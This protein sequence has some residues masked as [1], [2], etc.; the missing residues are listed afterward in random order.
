MQISMCSVTYPA[1]L[2]AYTGQASFLR[3]NN[4]L[5]SDTF[6]KSIPPMISGTFSIIQQSLALGCFPCVKIV[7]TSAKYEGQVYIPEINFILLIACVAVTA[8]FKTTTK[9]GIAV[10]FV[11]TLTSALLVL[12][13]IMIWKSHI[14]LVINYVVVELIYSSSVLYKFGYLPLAFAAVLMIIMYIWNDVYRRNSGGSPIKRDF[15]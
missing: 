15:Q 13:M 14:L 8:G 7:H 2:L 6:Y 10:V 3:Q 11:M 9:I 4:D 12:I 1:L 5:V